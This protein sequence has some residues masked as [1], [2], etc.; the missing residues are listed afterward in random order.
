MSKE[1]DEILAEFTDYRSVTT[2]WDDYSIAEKKSLD[3]V[4]T[5]FKTTLQDAKDDHRN[6]T[7]LALVMSWKASFWAGKPGKS[8]LCGLY[9]NLF[10]D[11]NEYAVTHLRGSKLDYYYDVTD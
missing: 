4:K 11:V 10:E 9:L 5:L 2:Y 6:L 1:F 7:E 3:E 8:S